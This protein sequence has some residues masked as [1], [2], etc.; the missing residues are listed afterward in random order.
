M[1]KRHTYEFRNWSTPE[2]PSGDPQNAPIAT[3]NTVGARCSP[4]FGAKYVKRGSPVEDGRLHEPGIFEGCLQT[5][6]D[7][8]SLLERIPI[9]SFRSSIHTA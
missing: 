7:H 6:R 5:G 1:F 4:W 3:E 9:D 8:P 2:H